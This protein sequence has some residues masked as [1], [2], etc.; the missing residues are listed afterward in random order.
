MD[1]GWADAFSFMLTTPSNSVPKSTVIA[2][3]AVNQPSG[4]RIYPY[5]TDLKIN[6]LKCTFM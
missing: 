2:A 3:Y 5:S 1:E 6:P 4:I